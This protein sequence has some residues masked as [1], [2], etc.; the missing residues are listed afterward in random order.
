MAKK[1]LPSSEVLRQLLHYECDTGRLFW[2]ERGPEWFCDNDRHTAEQ[3]ARIFNGRNAGR[4]AFTASDGKGYLQGQVCKYHTFAHRVAWAWV[5]GDWPGIIDHIDGDGTN[6][7][8][9]NLRAVSSKQNARNSAKPSSNTSGHVGVRW[10]DRIKRWEVNIG[11]DG[12]Q[13]Y[14]GSYGCIT[15]AVVARKRAEIV[16]G[17]HPNHGRDSIGYRPRGLICGVGQAV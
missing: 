8:L 3:L 4:L 2:K 10:R 12:R 13:R 5:H 9:S 16:A 7:R 14:V 15:A 11:C 17:F 1:P 6:N